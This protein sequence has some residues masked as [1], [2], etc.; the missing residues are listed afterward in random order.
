[1]QPP[2]LS[3]WTEAGSFV[4]L[5]GQLA[6]DEKRTLS[7]TDIDGQTA[8]TIKNIVQVLSQAGLTLADTVKVTVWLKN[9][10]DFP[11]FNESYARAFGSHAPARSTIVSQLVLPQALVEIEVVAR[12]PGA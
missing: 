8:Q 4:F 2:H 10:A 11:A 12:R 7:A 3:S 9:A 6:F 1:M 5:S